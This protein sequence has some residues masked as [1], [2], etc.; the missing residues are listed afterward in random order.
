MASVADYLRQQRLAKEQET[1]NLIRNAGSYSRNR[2]I[3]EALGQGTAEEQDRGFKQQA[4]GLL[5]GVMTGLGAPGRL[6]QAGLQE[7]TGNPNE[8]LRKVSGME[9]F[10][11]VLSGEINTG[12]GTLEGLKVRDDDSVLT[13]AGKFA[14]AFALDVATDPLS[15]IGAPASIS[16]KDAASLLVGAARKEGFLE[17][18]IAKSS[19]GDNL[20]EE[21]AKKA[22]TS[23]FAAIQDEL[24]LAADA[25]TPLDV[26]S[27]VGTRKLAAD[28]LADQ[29]GTALFTKGRTGLLKELESITGSR[30]NALSIF[31]SLP[32]EVKGGVVLTNLIGKPVKN[33]A[34]KYVRLTEGT[35]IP[36]LGAVAEKA[37]QARLATSV[38][39]GNIATRMLGGKAGPILADVKKSVLRRETEVAGKQASRLIDYVDIKRALADKVTGKFM[40]QGRAASAAL[41][42]HNSG[43]MYQG[44]DKELFDNMF[45]QAFFAPAMKVD[46]GT[47]SVAE[48]AAFDAAG[49]LRNEINGLREE[50]QGMGLE[51][52]LL[53][54]P[55]EWS[56]LIVTPEAYDRW[57][58]TGYIPDGVAQYNPEMARRSHVGF[59][60]DEEIARSSGFRD[61]ENP[62]V[63]YL[64]AQK[65]NDRLEKRAL[66]LGKTAEQAKL[67]RVFS[68]DPVQIM[69]M[70]GNYMAGAASTKRFV[71]ALTATGALVKDVP[72]VR[73]LLS[74]WDAAQVISGVAGVS[75]EVKR[76]AE[77]RVAK[78]KEEI[79]KLTG[80]Q[81]IDEIRARVANARNEAITTRDLARQRVATLSQQVADASAEIADATPRISQLKSQLKNYTE[82]VVRSTQDLAERQRAAKNVKARLATASKDLSNNQTTEQIIQELYASAPSGAEQSYYRELL[83]QVGD[84]TDNVAARV[85][86]EQSLQQSVTSELDQIKAARKAARDQGAQDIEQQ[87]YAYEQSVTKRNNLMVELNTARATRDQAVVVARGAETKIGLE[88]IDAID[89]VVQRYADDVSAYKVFKSANR[90]TKNTPPE[91]ATLIKEELSRLKGIAD[92]SKKLLKETLKVG[93]S[94]YSAV[95]KEYADQLLSLADNLSTEQF[96]AVR[97]LTD[98][99]K[100]SQ[101]IETV[102]QGARDED[103]VM[104]AMGDI[105]TTFNSIRERVPRSTFKNLTK[106]Q[107]AIL[108][109]SSKA[110]LKDRVLRE[111]RTTSE[112]VS[113]L[114]EVGYSVVG[115]TAG[116]SKLYATSGVLD[117][118][119]RTFKTLENPNQWEKFLN[120]YLDPLLLAWKAGITI[121][122]GPGYHLNNLVGGL[123]MNYLGNV[124]VKM[125]KIADEAVRMTNKAIKRI[126]VSNPNMSFLDVQ[127]LAHKEVVSTLNKQTVNGRGIGD[128][129]DEFTKRGGFNSTELG[130]LSEELARKGMA[131]A[132]DMFKRGVVIRPKYETEAGSKGEALYRKGLDLAFTN[133]IQRIGNNWAQGTEVRLRFSAFLD[134]F[135]RYD[136]LGA[137]MDKVHILHFDYAD[138][139][140]AEQW[141]RRLV[142]FYTWTRRNVPAQLR[143]MFMQPGKIQRFL[144]ANQEFQN[145]FAADGDESWLNQILP[146]YIDTSNG[147][148]SKFKFLDN[149]IGTFLR[150]PFEDINKTFSAT[151][152]GFVKGEALA[153]M[154]GPFTIPVELAT[155]RDIQSGRGLDPFG[156]DR[157]QTLGDIIPQLGTL[158]RTVGAAAGVSKAL[159]KDLPNIGFTEDQENKGVVTALNLLGIP[160]LF[161]MSAATISK[162]GTNAELVRRNQKQ[163]AKINEVA[164]E[165]GIDIEWVRK[166][167]RNG[168]P[169]EIVAQ[170]LNSGLGQ[171]QTLF[172]E[173]STLT[174]EQRMTAL[175]MLQGL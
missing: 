118:M 33:K 5:T 152:P 6:V 61:P 2:G 68:E 90:I 24:K 137:A 146:E 162:K 45:K 9:E 19:L 170:L 76:V 159:G 42:A 132:P 173:Q 117:V 29:L 131:T 37:N 126:Q 140:D 59:E 157:I 163:T 174:P 51:V 47:A 72:A 78:A 150:L 112:M 22:P 109:N 145:A 171:K 12:A 167:I 151:G 64:N 77:G 41:A 52:R 18:V 25:G 71:D 3:L 55:A 165:R 31:K 98:R 99:N 128:L 142:P 13:K 57:R 63:V 134:G 100:L 15:Y 73:R 127:A 26:A 8:A 32:E 43:N 121:G 92:E 53:G 107:E 17:S 135:E 120:D 114:D 87:I 161:G 160:A 93:K 108:L 130:A 16:R 56:P 35:V 28:Q 138:L 154:L 122:R 66:D 48:R 70:Y 97:I 79:A 14:G 103:T 80:E 58:R 124:G 123:Y 101:Y 125:F 166:Q 40:L 21:L 141:V 148:V 116:K 46:L 95:A 86:R 129:F 156:K 4:M 39:P 110:K 153:S 139:S 38:Y 94:N 106:T 20:V 111:A 65:A 50:A 175:Q 7:L 23:R 136:D 104:K 113:A 75:D 34:G 30:V 164:A 69:Q 115:K 169:P 10:R 81:N 144:Y 158:Q 67:E 147:F 88:S 54:D 119:E 102:R 1:E 91:I 168:T 143:A 27:K 11:K 36:K 89:G 155:G 133:P 96:N 74:E 62:E 83:D 44:A 60:P 105:V 84:E 82:T 149:N 85:Q 49:R 172:P